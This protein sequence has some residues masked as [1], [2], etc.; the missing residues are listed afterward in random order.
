[1]SLVTTRRV[2]WIFC[3]VSLA[4]WFGLHLR[5]AKSGNYMVVFLVVAIGVGLMNLIANYWTRPTPQD[6]D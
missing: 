6:R 1:M 4:L 5:L 3:G 2:L